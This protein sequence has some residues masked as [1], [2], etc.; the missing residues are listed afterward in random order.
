M[1]IPDAEQENDGVKKKSRHERSFVTFSDFETF[2]ENFPTQTTKQVI[3][4][5]STHIVREAWFELEKNV[6]QI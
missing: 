4:A 6:S 1:T 2:R 3:K 5:T